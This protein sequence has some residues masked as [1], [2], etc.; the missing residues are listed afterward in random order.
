VGR[1]YRAA[2]IIL[3]WCTQKPTLTGHGAGLDSQIAAQ[4]SVRLSLAVATPTESRTVFGEDA[5]DR[6]WDA[7][8]LPM[9]GHALL[10]DQDLGPRAQP[11]PLKMRAMSP[12]NVIALPDRPVWSRPGVTAVERLSEAV[13]EETTAERAERIRNA[14]E[15]DPGASQRQLAASLGVPLSA[16]Q[17]AL[18]D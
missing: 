6:G 3:V 2:E 15:A 9:P 1:K 17:R 11:R 12:A 5:Q 7:H 13:R 18:R 4:L 8:L 10:R 16:I 14:A